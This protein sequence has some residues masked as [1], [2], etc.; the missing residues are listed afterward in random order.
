MP[1]LQAGLHRQPRTGKTY[2]RRLQHSALP[3]G[4]LRQAVITVR[5][6]RKPAQRLLQDLGQRPSVPKQNHPSFS[7]GFTCSVTHMKG[8]QQAD[9]GKT[10]LTR[11]PEHHLI[12]GQ[13]EQ[14]FE[15]AS[16][17]SSRL[18]TR[19]KPQKTLFEAM[20]V[21]E[22]SCEDSASR[23]Q[24]SPAGAVVF[25]PHRR[26][27]TLLAQALLEQAV[28]WIPEVLSSRSAHRENSEFPRAEAQ[29]MERQKQYRSTAMT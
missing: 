23:R 29:S 10:T 1:G 9:T 16:D 18:R 28:C 3:E 21:Q 27:L 26:G 6:D 12:L 11:R 20:G 14:L 15:E 7:H 2:N 19:L 24:E 17:K 25:R 13:Q 4:W 22:H 5:V 8:I